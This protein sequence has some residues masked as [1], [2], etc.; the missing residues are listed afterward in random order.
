MEPEVYCLF[1][2]IVPAA[3]VGGGGDL[4]M[5]CKRQGL[6]S[7]FCISL[8]NPDGQPV[9]LLDKLNAISTGPTSC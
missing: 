9:D 7:D 2:D 1:A 6:V 3:A 4:E 8:P 5:V